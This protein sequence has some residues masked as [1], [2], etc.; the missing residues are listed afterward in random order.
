MKKE[1]VVGI[2]LGGIFIKVGLV[3]EIGD[4]VVV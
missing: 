2:D 3:F 4:V 1:V